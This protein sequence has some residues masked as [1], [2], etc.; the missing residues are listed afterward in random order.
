MR[1]SDY[2]AAA[3]AGARSILEAVATWRDNPLRTQVNR[4]LWGRWWAA[5][6][7][8][9]TAA[10]IAY[11]VVQPIPYLTG[12]VP[13]LVFLGFV[14][15]LIR[16]LL[17]SGPALFAFVVVWR[18]RRL[19]ESGE[20]TWPNRFEVQDFGAT[21]FDAGAVPVAVATLALGAGSLLADIAAPRP[22]AP[23]TEV[24]G[25]DTIGGLA[26]AESAGTFAQTVLTV[27]LVA[28]ILG[29]HRTISKG[30]GKLISAGFMV[31]GMHIGLAFSVPWMVSWW[32]YLPFIGQYA[33]RRSVD[34]ALLAFDLAV[35]C[36]VWIGVRE[37][38]S[39]LPFWEVEPPP[40]PPPPTTKEESADE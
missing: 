30:L 9:L 19:R 7:V 8:L 28:G 24:P 5:V 16:G 25:L 35:A 18:V 12:L 34:F 37:K 11:E 36:A 10:A 2:G 38:C 31:W 23:P 29:L 32:A 39:Q 21:L 3:I 13:P 17:L 27:A 40:P 20:D 14:P 22:G 4:A 6:L 15:N 1:F 33:P 26:I